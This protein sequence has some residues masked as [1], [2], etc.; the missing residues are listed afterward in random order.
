MT[1][2]PGSKCRVLAAVGVACVAGIAD[3]QVLEEVVVTAQKYE[4]AISDVGIS[5][6]AFSGAQLK[7]LGV[8]DTVGISAQTPG[9]IVT[10]F[11]G[12]TTTVFN[13]RGAGQLDFNDQQEAPVAVYLDGA[14]VSFL[15]GVGFNFYDLERV[16]VLRGSQ[17]TLFG[18]NATGGLVQIISK[19]PTDTL[20]GY[21]ELTGGDY[22]MLKAEGALNGPLSE[23]ISGRL[24]VYHE[25]NDGYIENATGEDGGDRNNNSGRAQLLFEPTEDL[26][27]LVSGRYAID[28]AEGQIYDVHAA[29]FDADG[30]IQAVAPFGSATEQDFLSYCAG[31]I[32]F[33]GV[34]GPPGGTNIGSGD[35]FNGAPNNRDPFHS[36]TNADSYYKRDHYGATVT[37]DYQWGPGTLTSITDFQDFKKRY[38]EDADSTPLILWEFQQDLDATQWSEELRYAAESSWGRYILGAYYLQIEDDGRASLDAVNTLGISFQNFYGLETRTYAAFGQIEYRL[39]EDFTAIAG[40]RWTEDRKEFHIDVGCGFDFLANETP[41]AENCAFFAPLVQGTGLPNTTRDEG[42]W[43]GNAELDWKPSDDLLIY[44]KVVRGHKAGGFN[45]GIINFFEPSAATYD[46]E[47]PLTYEAGLKAAFFEQKARVSASAFY[48]DYKDFQTFTQAGA[49]LIVFN[50]DAEMTGGELELTLNPWEGWDVLLGISLLDATQKDVPGP[51][52]LLDRPMPNAPDVTY[53]ALAR[54]SGRCSAVSWPFRPT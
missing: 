44:G 12:G 49:N 32:A 48:T 33:N 52:G 34:P 6:T 2:D 5:V 21:I 35:C 54:Y 25:S 7:A 14:Y 38:A 30:Y 1:Y 10:E 23:T 22:G 4:Q 24:S 3:A 9:L 27:V 26:S 53:N 45:G 40:L 19:K 51:G 47:L 20:E 15:A 13:I 18:R 46:A 36:S 17:G 28:D 39:G 43:S 16:E 37:V 41:T 42:D 8:S 50:V 11:G 31:L 29:V